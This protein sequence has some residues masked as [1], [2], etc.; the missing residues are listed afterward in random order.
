MDGRHRCR[1]FPHRA[2]VHRPHAGR[3]PIPCIP[4]VCCLGF[5]SR[6]AIDRWQGDVI[7]SPHDICLRLLHTVAVG[8]RHHLSVVPVA[9]VAVAGCLRPDTSQRSMEDQGILGR[10]NMFRFSLLVLFAII[11][12]V[13]L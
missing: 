5:R 8:R 2:I 12:N 4:V 6:Y 10:D 1:G 3:L 7:Q 11:N 9:M 13:N